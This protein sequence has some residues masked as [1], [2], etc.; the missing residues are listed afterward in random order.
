M[1][2]DDKRYLRDDTSMLQG[3]ANPDLGHGYITCFG[4]V[5]CCSDFG[6]ERVL[7][8]TMTDLMIF[9][10]LTLVD[11]MVICGVDYDALFMDKTQ[12][13]HLG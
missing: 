2:D 4:I 10:G 3:T 6:H 7:C 9:D 5:W 1:N 12:G 11:D 8:F 13:Q